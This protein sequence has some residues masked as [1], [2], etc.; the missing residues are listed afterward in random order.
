MSSQI[1]LSGGDK[2]YSYSGEIFGDVSVPAS[3][4]M[5]TI[6][7]TGLRDSLIQVNGFFGKDVST[8]NGQQLGIQIKLD[9]VII[10]NE[11]PARSSEIYTVTNNTYSLFMPRNSKL[12]IISLNTSGNNTQIRG[13]NL[14]GYYL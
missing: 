11:Q 2:Y 12:E 14:I 1:L 5:I 9:N 4:P 10:L 13:V 7:N 3:I 6:D 8:T